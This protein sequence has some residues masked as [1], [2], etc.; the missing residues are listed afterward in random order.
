[1]IHILFIALLLVCWGSFLNV[2]AHRLITNESI[3]TPR[4]HCPHCMTTLAWYDL[5]P[6]ISWLYW[7]MHGHNWMLVITYHRFFNGKFCWHYLFDIHTPNTRNAH[8][9][10]TFSCN[11]CYIIRALSK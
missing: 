11:G 2:V 3:I 9:I 5:I 7:I 8:P 6:I 4:S 1:M 10:W